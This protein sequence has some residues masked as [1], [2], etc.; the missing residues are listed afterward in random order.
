MEVLSYCLVLSA[1]FRL[2][3]RSLSYCV[4]ILSWLHLVFLCTIVTQLSFG[5]FMLVFSFRALCSN[6]VGTGAQSY[7]YFGIFFSCTACFCSSTV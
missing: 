6:S 3:F 1:R 4:D 2:S 5:N 7:V